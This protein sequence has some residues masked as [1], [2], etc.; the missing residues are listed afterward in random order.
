[1]GLKIEGSLPNKHQARSGV[2]DRARAQPCQVPSHA[3]PFLIDTM[4][5][6]I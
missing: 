2:I 5:L 1:M 3:R 6:G 4:D